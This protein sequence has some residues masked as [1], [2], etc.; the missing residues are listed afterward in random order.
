MSMTIGG[1]TIFRPRSGTSIHNSLR[2]TFDCNCNLQRRPLPFIQTFSFFTSKTQVT[3]TA[4]SVAI[5]QW[6]WIF[7]SYFVV[8]YTDEHSGQLASVENGEVAVDNDE[9]VNEDEEQMMDSG[10]SV[11]NQQDN[12]QETYSPDGERGTND[13]DLLIMDTLPGVDD[14]EAVKVSHARYM[15]IECLYFMKLFQRSYCSSS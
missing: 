7:D 5:L 14:P 15:L 2:Q 4:L 11:S 8:N 6:S 1:I 12:V 10:I 13:I 9:R 3:V